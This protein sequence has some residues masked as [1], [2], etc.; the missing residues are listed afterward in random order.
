MELT[1]KNYIDNEKRIIKEIEDSDFISFD[2]EMTGIDSD[3]NNSL[4]DTP[5]IRYLKYKASAEKYKIIQLGLTLFKFNSR[6]SY[7]EVSPYSF[8]LFPCNSFSEDNLITCELRS[9]LFN[10]KNGIDFNNWIKN[11]IS[12]LNDRQYK[13]LYRRILDDNVNLN[14]EVIHIN[15]NLDDYYECEKIINDI[16]TNFYNSMNICPNYM[17]KNIPNFQIQYI[18]NQLNDNLFFQRNKLEKGGTYIF[19]TKYKNEEE[20]KNL[21][22]KDIENNLNKLER[23][24]GVKHLYETILKK[25]KV[26]IGHNISLDILFLINSFG[27]T[28]PKT[29]NEFKEYISN[30]FELY[31]TKLIFNSLKDK[32]PILRNVNPILEQM[33]PILKSLSETLYN[34][35]IVNTKDV[36][37]NENNFHNAG[38]DSF[39][40]GICFLS[41][42]YLN[43]DVKFKENFK[44]K[45]FFMKSLYTCFDFLNDEIMIE[46]NTINYCLKAIKRTGDIQLN[47]IFKNSKFEKSIVKVLN[48]DTFNTLIIMVNKD[49]FLNNQNEFEN[50]LKQKENMKHY[51]IYTLEEFR[52]KYMK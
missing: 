22:K 1:Y 7:Y 44:N 48:C 52:K 40:T 43:T 30:N 27:K 6:K 34:Y 19:I 21:I 20:K 18:K 50:I 8:Y 32:S 31:D 29:Y 12:Y 2:L 46:Q 49:D 36:F 16:K 41:L 14:N 35:K 9:L 10:R 4:I 23:K 25:K 17:I 5:E 51:T 45:V 3:M 38:F 15:K 42:K 13:E 28:L 24:K 11:G 39:I 37:E 33:F 47:I 26:L